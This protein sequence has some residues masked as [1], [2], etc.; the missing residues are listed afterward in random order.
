MV[1]DTQLEYY[2]ALVKFVFTYL[3]LPQIALI[4][5]GLLICLFRYKNLLK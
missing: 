2:V 4:G 3:V 1:A 5:I